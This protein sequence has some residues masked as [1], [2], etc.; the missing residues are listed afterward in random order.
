MRGL[1]IFEEV[2]LEEYERENKRIRTVDEALAELPNGAVSRKTINGREYIYLQWRE[3]SAIKS[4]YV[5]QN[6]IE[7]T[8]KLIERRN[9]FREVKKAANRK[10][11]QIEMALGKELISEYIES[12]GVL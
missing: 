12:E 10:K 1:S 3:G 4:R 6:K 7:E 5:P 2:L 11:K 8:L 9:H